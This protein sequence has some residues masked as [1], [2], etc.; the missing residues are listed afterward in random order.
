[1]D[2]SVS[3]KCL[4]TSTVHEIKRGTSLLEIAKTLQI[5]L[6]HRIFGALVNNELEELDYEVYQPKQIQFI[7]ITHPDGMRMYTRS[8]CFLL[9]KA[10]RD[11]YPDRRLIIGHSVSNGIYCKITGNGFVITDEI[12]ASLA[13]RMRS[14]VRDDLAFVRV[15]EETTEVI[16]KA[17]ENGL[18]DKVS[19]LKFRGLNYKSYYKLDGCI[20]FFY[21]YLL[22]SASYIDVFDLNRYFDGLLLR[23]PMKSNP[24]KVEELKV[25]DN[26]ITIFQEYSRWNNILQVS[27]IGELNDY[28]I[29]GN[30]EKLI[31]ISEALHEK[32]IAQIADLICSKKDRVKIILISGP[33]SSGKTTFAKRLAIQMLVNGI[34]PLNISLDD[35]FVNRELTPRDESG[36]YDFE[37]LEAIDIELFNQH[38]TDLINGKK[39][40][41]PKFSFEKGTRTFNGE[42]LEMGPDNMLVIEGIHGLNPRLTATVA[43]ESKFMIYVSALTALN[44]DNHNWVSAWD[45]RLIRR[46]VRDYRYRKYSAKE[47]IARWPSVL[48]GE[49]KHILPFREKA[50]TMFNS[51]LLYELAVLKHYAVPILMEIQQNQV[52]YAEAKRLLNFLNYFKVIESEEIPPTSIIREFLGGSSF[53]Y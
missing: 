44:I 25:Q 3:V 17:E 20:N 35:Y 4:N 47:T 36:D 19:L 32:K 51:A 6:N 15:I 40:T 42:T 26:M 10:V 29:R 37:A 33:S 45:N 11:L 8:L 30:S 7:D 22:P 2:K 41:L 1:M 28:T 24:T 53:N 12:V 48:K 9:Y 49:E 50:D 16:K 21:G 23:L 13:E 31:K 38:L 39:V 46:I 34:K 18:Y 14:Y 5:K 43:R 27:N 52:E